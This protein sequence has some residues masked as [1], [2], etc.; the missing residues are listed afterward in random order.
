[1]KLRGEVTAKIAELYSRGSAVR[2]IAKQVGI[3]KTSVHRFIMSDIEKWGRRSKIEAAEMPQDA[4]TKI[5][6]L[7][8]RGASVRAVS[9]AVGV[10]KSSVHRLLSAR[11]ERRGRIRRWPGAPDGVDRDVAYRL[12]AKYGLTVANYDA[13]LR[14]QRGCCAICKRKPKGG[15]KLAVDHCHDSGMVRGLLCARCNTALGQL[16]DDP[17]IIK[18]MLDYSLSFVHVS[19]A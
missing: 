15:R 17:N 9:K 11:G 3:S 19:A 16:R 10:S 1:M 8:Q 5:V 14:K 13:L 12:W 2:E 7:H 4:A 18:A 6:E